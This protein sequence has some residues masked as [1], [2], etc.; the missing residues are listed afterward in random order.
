MW[1]AFTGGLG[2][3]GAAFIS[4]VGWIYFARCSFVTPRKVCPSFRDENRVERGLGSTVFL[5]QHS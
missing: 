5:D 1:L 3:V 2:S 4:R